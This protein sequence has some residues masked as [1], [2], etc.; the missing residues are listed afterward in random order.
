MRKY[1]LHGAVSSLRLNGLA[2]GGE[3]HRGHHAKR[4]ISLLGDTKVRH[5][6]TVVTFNVTNREHL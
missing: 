6:A 2:V 1:N 3:Q 5:A 4:A